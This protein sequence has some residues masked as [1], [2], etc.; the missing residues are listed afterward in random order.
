MS[1]L[2]YTIESLE[3]ELQVRQE[4]INAQ[5]QLIAEGR[6]ALSEVGFA[7]YCPFQSICFMSSH[8]LIHT[9]R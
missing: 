7:S 8:M 1:V 2:K 5:R 4:Q 3:K 9:D 6:Q